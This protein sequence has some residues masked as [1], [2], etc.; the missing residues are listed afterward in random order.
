MH[1]VTYNVQDEE[2]GIRSHLSVKGKSA[3][4]NIHVGLYSRSPN[5]HGITN[6]LEFKI[7][8]KLLIIW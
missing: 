7:L 1:T 8:I 6:S 4:D 5:H 2:Q 3:I